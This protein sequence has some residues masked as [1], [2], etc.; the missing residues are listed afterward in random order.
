MEQKL[1]NEIKKI[2]FMKIGNAVNVGDIEYPS[3]LI[4]GI[5]KYSL[6]IPYSLDKEISDEF[7]GIEISTSYLN[8]ENNSIKV[9]YLQAVETINLDK[10]AYIG[11]HFLDPNNRKS[12]LADPY[13]WIDEWKDIF[14]NSL[15]KKMVYDVIGE[16][17]SLRYIY[18]DDQT[19]SWE[20]PK[21]GTHDIV[22]NSILY[23]VKSTQKKLKAEITINSVFQLNNE[24]TLK[25]Y[26]C[27][28]EYKPYSYSINSLV[29]ELD[30]F[31]YDINQLE[32]S[33]D[34]LG[35]RKGSR[36]RDVS[37]DVL[38]IREYTV[39]KDTFPLL[40]LE[41]INTH[42]PKNNIISYNI[43]LDL[44]SIEYVKIK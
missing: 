9:L 40:S 36:F 15:K 5:D 27:R 41:T 18:K 21:N 6:A 16:L 33:L 4:R 30:I 29:K 14:G 11:S 12:I 19:A 31:G 23:E 39:S 35:Y 2:P 32:S 38:E 13:K 8:F 10:F 26:F 28:L 25:I 1:I 20:G 44:N 34:E 17:I 22:S 7:V 42:A 3:Y 24:K 43:T 37:Y